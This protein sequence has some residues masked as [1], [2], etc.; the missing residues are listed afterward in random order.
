[1]FDFLRSIR[2]AALLFAFCLMGCGQGQPPPATPTPKTDRGSAAW[3]KDAKPGESLIAGLD[4]ATVHWG[5]WNG[6]V[7]FV[8][9]FDRIASSNYGSTSTLKSSA[10]GGWEQ[11]YT[12]YF[13]DAPEVSVECTTNDGKTGTVRVNGREFDLGNGRVFLLSGGGNTVRVQQLKRDELKATA[14]NLAA[15]PESIVSLK[16][17][18][19]VQEFFKNEKAKP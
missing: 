12:S 14:G 15:P 18:S 4:L 1:M 17:D 7:V 6:D 19:V 8:L 11:N 10:M 5:L 13:N 3:K 2:T 9:W 16:A